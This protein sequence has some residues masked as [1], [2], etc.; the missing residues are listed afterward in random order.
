[1][2]ILPILLLTNFISISAYSTELHTN[3]FL[4]SSILE[5]IYGPSS[6]SIL[7][8]Y[9]LS[10]PN[11]FGG[12]CSLMEKIEIKRGTKVLDKSSKYH[13]RKGISES[14]VSPFSTDLKARFALTK[15]VCD[16]VSKNKASQDHLMD[17]LRGSSDLE[18]KIDELIKLFYPSLNNTKSLRD[19]IIKESL[20]SED[21]SLKIL[22]EFDLTKNLFLNFNTSNIINKGSH[23]LCISEKWQKINSSAKEVDKYRKCYALLTQ[24]S[25]RSNDPRAGKVLKGTISAN[26]ACFELLEGIDLKDHKNPKTQEEIDVLRTLHSFH[27]SWFPN[28]MA[29]MADDSPILYDIVELEEPALFVT[30]SLFDKSFK[31][32]HILKGRDS[33]KGVRSSTIIPDFLI[34]AGSDERI[35]R[36]EN[37]KVALSKSESTTWSPT[38]LQRGALI[39]IEV[40]TSEDI[41]PAHSNQLFFPV[42]SKSPINIHESL[43]GG[44]LGSN[45]YIL[46]NNGR[47]HGNIS[48][49]KK[50]MMRAY[51]QNVVRDLLCRDLPVITPNDSINYINKKSKLSWS[52]D[53]NCMSCHATMDTMAGLLRNVE[54]VINDVNEQGSSHIKFHK[55]DR[56]VPK[57]VKL[58]DTVEKYHLTKAQ[59]NFV[60]RDI[61]NNFINTRVESLDEL[62]IE[63]SKTR[64]LYACT[65]T[66]YFK[67]FTGRDIK[68]TEIEDLN[69]KRLKDFINDQINLFQKEQDLQMLIKRIISSPW[70]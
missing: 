42:F 15:S 59:G 13:C 41:L 1:M 16:E 10:K 35:E 29:Y 6:K 7:E 70:F 5:N 2:K 20:N 25:P 57:G 28:Y 69:D 30:K 50:V 68:I 11:A 66:R 51:S 65:T 31:Y 26:K 22:K 21:L 19:E 48:D 3:R 54:L 34:T 53:K 46:F 17:S 33:L 4:T 37:Y 67:F 56:D 61:E 8:K 47:P 36:R 39:G 62:G 24:K 63:M 9:I 23:L 60:Y 12:P 64:D 14:K 55:A 27:N 32:S 38:H 18:S 43:G 45:S 58:F 49:G 44:I 40:N 52:Q